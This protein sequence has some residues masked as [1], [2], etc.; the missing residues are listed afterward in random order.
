MKA[1]D[2]RVFV[3]PMRRDHMRN[4]PHTP[5]EAYQR[6]G[7][8]A[9]GRAANQAGVIVKG[10]HAGQAMLAQKLGDHLEEGFRIELGPDLPMQ[11]DGGASIDE[12]GNLHHMLLFPFWISR[13]L[14]S[15]FEV[16]LDFLPPLAQLQGL[17]LASVVL[18]DAARLAQNLPDRRLRAWQAYTSVFE[19]GI[20]VDV[21]QDRFRPWDALQVL[22]RLHSNLQDALHD[23]RLGGDGG[24]RGVPGRRS[25]MQRHD[26]SRI[27]LA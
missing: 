18:V 27:G 23:S 10:E 19:C 24:R 12:V 2:V 17:G 26:I 20:A 14:T 1:F 13:H 3:W 6:G 15:I 4:H 5:E 25:G 21:I 7:E 22:W 16:E 11:P 8:I 9:S